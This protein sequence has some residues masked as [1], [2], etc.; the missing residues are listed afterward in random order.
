[1]QPTTLV[2]VAD[3]PMRTTFGPRRLI[4]Y[5]FVWILR[6]S[7]WWTVRQVA[8]DDSFVRERRY[9]LT[10]G[11]VALARAGT[12]DSYLWDDART[13]TH[14]FVHFGID[15]PGHLGPEDDWPAIRSTLV[16]PILDGICAYLLELAG[17]QSELARS[18]SDELVRLLLDLFVSGPLEETERSLPGFLVAI[19]DYVRAAW[20]TGGMR[21]L[22]VPE[23]ADAASISVGHL[24]RLFR[25]TYGSGPARAFELVRL[26]RAAISLQRSNAT[27]SEIAEVSGFANPYHFS[28]RFAAVYGTP[29]GTFRSL[30]YSPDPL[31]PV[32]DAGLL[33]VAHAL[34]SCPSE[35]GGGVS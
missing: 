34:L 15:D 35:R 9:R 5:E 1:M 26:A 24:F 17:Q 13:S 12:V 16:A 21:I 29:P 31:K 22:G 10:P 14:A 18:R 4:D 2:Q 20:D 25:E 19:T 33:P 23:L 7:A 6:G 30:K 3:Y 11:M 32:R 27:I 28:R 8:M